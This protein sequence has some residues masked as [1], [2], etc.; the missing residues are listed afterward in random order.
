MGLYD[1]LAA[2]GR[3]GQ[4]LIDI[5]SSVMAQ[6]TR[7]SSF[8]PPEG[9]SSW[10]DDAVRDSVTQ[11]FATKAGFVELCW[12]RAHDDH[13]LEL[14]FRTT[15]KNFLIDQAKHTDTGK[16]RRRLGPRVGNP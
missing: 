2:S 16:L 7:T 4:L 1:E 12:A 5:L 13:T 10:D 14:V 3:G 9:F 11:L 6:V 8:P 15:V